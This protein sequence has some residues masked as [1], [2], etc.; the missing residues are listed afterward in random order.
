M[1][2]TAELRA[3]LAEARPY[4]LSHHPV[5]ERDRCYSPALRGR[6]VH[7]CARCTGIY[8]GIVAGLVAFGY[9]PA[10]ATSFWLVT[11]LPFGAL[12]EW[13]VTT[14]TT[15]RGYNVVRTGTG[16]ALGFAYGLGLGR[17]FVGGDLAVLAVG[18]GYGVA[19]VG[20]LTVAPW[21]RRS[22]QGISGT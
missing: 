10:P 17:S 3:G 5:G 22:G 4:L 1:V 21:D 19:A 13:A 15:R 7:L 20:L 14:F 16:L 12:L 18:V 2:D 8:P 6:E 11:L 9:G